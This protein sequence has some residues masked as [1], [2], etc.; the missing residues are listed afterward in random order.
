MKFEFFI[1]SK[2]LKNEVGG[3]TISRPIVKISVISICLA[4]LV[5]LITIAVVIGFQHE[6]SDKVLGF[7]SHAFIS[8]SASTSLFENEA[9]LKQQDFLQDIRNQTFIK[10]IQPIAYKPAIFQTDKS[11]LK[12]Q[13]IQ[14]IL[15]K[16][17]DQSYD[18]SFFQQ[19]LIAGRLPDYDKSHKSDEIL[20]SSRVAKDL[21]YRCGDTARTFFVKNQP[22]RRNFKIVGIFETGMEDFDKK[23][24][25]SDIRHIQELNDWGIQAS[26]DVLDTLANGYLVIKANVVGGNGNYRYDWGK[27]YAN[28]AGFT[29]YPEKDTVFR[30]IVSDY[31]MFID[32]KGEETSIPDTAYLEVKVRNSSGSRFPLPLN[33]DGTVKKSGIS[34]DGMS[35]SINIP[36][37]RTSFHKVDGKGSFQNYI[38]A[39][40]INFKS[41]DRFDQN[42]ETLK[43]QVNFIHS[44]ENQDLRVT[45]LKENQ[46]EIFVWLSFLDINVW[47][48]IVLMLVIGIINMG[49]AM[50]V[51]ILVKTPF[52]GMMKAMGASNWTIRKIFLIQVGYLIL[53]GMFW[54]N[55]IGISVC[56]LQDYFKIIR[57]NPEVYYLNAVP[58]ELSLV[59]ILWVNALTLIVCLSAMLIP[60]YVISRISPAKSIRFN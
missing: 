21:N 42:I 30:V 5:N 18:F 38:G 14:S 6:V 55:L 13:E 1:A 24:V 41:W 43:K 54:G 49:S 2:N 51:L 8:S 15:V 48:I 27:G 17:V 12:S 28:Y 19:N 44:S 7:G 34:N 47:I 16:G 9:I 60:S 26:V 11:K 23:I 32:G 37:R 56:L 20:V 35:F 40:E 36:E 25:I 58:I 29:W 4:V 57:L 59:S 53:R 33:S 3:K 45:S 10:N 22:V 50:L 52:I 39:Y 46:E 31:W